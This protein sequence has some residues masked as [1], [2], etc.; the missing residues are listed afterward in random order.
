[1]Q[2]A[3]TGV[4][5]Q[6]LGGLHRLWCFLFGSLYYAA[7]GAW[8]WAFISFVTAN[9]LFIGLPLWNRS[10]IKAHYENNGWREIDA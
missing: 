2:N 3:H 10:I 7:K 4:R 8:G 1:M 9:G 5:R 6:V